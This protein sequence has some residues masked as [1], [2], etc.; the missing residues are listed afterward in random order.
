[1]SAYASCWCT[2]SG[3]VK[4]LTGAFVLIVL[5]LELDGG[6]PDLLAVRVCLEGEGE[7]ASGCRDITLTDQVLCFAKMK[8]TDDEKFEQ[9][10]LNI[11]ED[12]QEM[13]QLNIKQN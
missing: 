12:E 10:A 2:D 3:T 1:M 7:D 9:T 5:R 13:K 4:Q 11:I 8:H 6:E